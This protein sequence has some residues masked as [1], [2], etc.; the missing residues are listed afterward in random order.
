[1]TA[2]GESRAFEPGGRL[3]VVTGNAVVAVKPGPRTVR[4][5][6]A[7]GTTVTAGRAVLAAP[8]PVALALHADL[9]DD[10]R[11]FLTAAIAARRVLAAQ[12]D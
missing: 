6:L 4:L 2:R 3:D 12:G 10:E 1:M 11:P 9:P 5:H 7:D 8:A